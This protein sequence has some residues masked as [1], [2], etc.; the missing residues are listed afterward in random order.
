M[1]GPI[2]RP[3][4]KCRHMR[5][6]YCAHPAANTDALTEEPV[7]YAIVFRWY[8][9]CTPAG[10]HWQP[11]TISQKLRKLRKLIRRIIGQ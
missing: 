9:T 7:V 5:G 10:K 11:L 6:P 4:W 3:C 8:G 1:T 2:R